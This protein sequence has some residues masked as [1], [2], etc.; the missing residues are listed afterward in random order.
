MQRNGKTKVGD[1]AC[2]GPA[3]HADHPSLARNAFAPR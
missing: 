2:F 3:G 1:I